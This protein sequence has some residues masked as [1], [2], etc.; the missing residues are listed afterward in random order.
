MKSRTLTLIA[1][2]TLFAATLAAPIRLAAQDQEHHKKHKKQVLYSVKDLGTLGGIGGAGA[3]AEAIS[4]N[5][6]A[7]GTSNLAGDT[8]LHSFL[9]RDGEMTDLGTLGGL[10]SNENGVL[11]SDNRGL[12]AGSAQTSA[13]DPLAENWG[14]TTFFCNNNGPCDGYQNVVLGFVWQDGVMTALP[15]LGGNNA[16]AQ[17]IND[18]G[19]VVG[20]AENSVHNP[21]C[22]PPQVLDF[23]AVI[24][25][26]EGDREDGEIHPHQLPPLPGDTD[27]VA[28]QI[29]NRGQIV[30]VSGPCSQSVTHAVL[31]EHDTVSDMGNLGGCCNSPVDINSHGQVVGLSNT[32][33]NT[34]F[35]A[36]L[37]Q[38]G[39]VMT[40]LGT[41]PGDVMSFA[42][43]INDQGQI[44]G[45][46][47]TDVFFNGCRAMLWQNGVMTDL[48][49]LVK[50][51][52]TPLQLFFGNDINSRGEI[53]AYAFNPSNGEF[54]AALAIPCD[55]EDADNEGCEDGAEGTS[56][57]RAATSQ[58]P[59]VV[60]P[61]NIR[62]MLRQRL[63]FG[64]FGA[65][66]IRPQ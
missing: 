21:E 30:G 23:E 51:G 65:G 54:R 48:N 66:P 41:P 28:G 10:N 31:W 22:V 49:T 47:C 45:G 58:N 60:L 16:R 15:T 2:M 18:H 46:S 43:G 42:F 57:V 35:H 27:A 36:F 19:Q 3:T 7:V 4:N 63:G 12:I 32:T 29:N 52:S 61:E 6:W 20:L 1:A 59:K 17:G 14:A 62:R 55:E 37:W 24:W 39:G 26:R 11:I 50:P 38:K 64:R 25:E 34:T 53:A 56:A 40:D 9:W 13:V 5:G 8:T 33:G 44:V